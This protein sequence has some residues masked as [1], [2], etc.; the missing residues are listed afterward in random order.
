MARTCALSAAD[1]R[2]RLGCVPAACCDRCAASSPCVRPRADLMQRHAG[3]RAFAALGAR[4]GFGGPGPG[5]MRRLSPFE[6]PHPA[7]CR[8]RSAAPQTP[9]RLGQS[10]D[11]C[12]GFDRRHPQPRPHPR[13]SRRDGS[14]G[15]TDGLENCSQRPAGAWPTGWAC[16]P[17]E[18]PAHLPAQI[19]LSADRL[20]SWR[21][22]LTPAAT[23]IEMTMKHRARQKR[24]GRA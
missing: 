18:K 14:N 3:A 2:G 22:F 6:A 8:G 21:S 1:A 15:W 17:P 12:A 4:A 11:P 7:P 23:V 13:K 5:P 19:G 24:C 9:H 20:S 10:P 16:A